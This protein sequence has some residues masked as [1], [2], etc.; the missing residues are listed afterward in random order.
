LLTRRFRRSL[1]L[2]G[3]LLG[4]NYRQHARKHRVQLPSAAAT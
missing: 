1:D 4:L 2:G 3:P